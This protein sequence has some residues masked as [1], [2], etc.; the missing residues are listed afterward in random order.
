METKGLLSSNIQKLLHKSKG[1]G[2]KPMHP[3]SLRAFKR[4]Q[5]HDLKHPGSANLITSKQKELPSFTDR[6]L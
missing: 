6:F 2:T 5:E 4:H 3:S 1:Q